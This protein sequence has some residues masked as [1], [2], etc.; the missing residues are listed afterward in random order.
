MLNEDR[1]KLMTK[2]AAYEN[3]EGKKEIPISKFYR[4]D[5]VT[6]NMLKT[7]ISTTIAFCL[8]V[9]IFVLYKIEYFMANIH[10]MDLL[11]LGKFVL[12]YYIIFIL[13]NVVIAF[14]VYMIKYS[15][16]KKGVRQYYGQ[17]KR[18]SKIYDKE[19]NKSEIRKEL[20]GKPNNDHFT[21][22]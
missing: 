21:G 17:L 1:I 14:F 19:G 10:K 11:L 3:K 15:N 16:A 22:I 18:L 20:G 7:V 2:M 8:I 4:I 5:Y 12:K 9:G 6:L 13:I